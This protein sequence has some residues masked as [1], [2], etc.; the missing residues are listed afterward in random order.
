[1]KKFKIFLIVFVL[2]FFTGCGSNVK[3]VHNLDNFKNVVAE[4]EL[5]VSDNMV[6]YTAD[7]IKEAM[8]GIYDDLSIE[9]VIYDND[10]NAS[11]VQDSQ[12]KSFMNMKSTNSVI[13]KEKGKNYYKVTMITNGYYLVSSRIENTLI[14]TKTL[15][16][17]K[18]TVD[19]ILD[20]LN[21]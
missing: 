1:M 15:L 9:M 12:I 18:D 17:N 11:N 2:L 13:N 8:V 3:E 4:K 7:Y 19:Y 5:V 16:K 20:K 21:Y 14:F 10:D 6:N